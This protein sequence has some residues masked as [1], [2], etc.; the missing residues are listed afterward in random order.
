MG[1]E[2]CEI[3]I[4]CI[5]SEQNTV[6]HTFLCIFGNVMNMIKD[7][8]YVI[9][10]ILIFRVILCF[11]LVICVAASVYE[12]IF[13]PCFNSSNTEENLNP[14]RRKTSHFKSSSYSVTYVNTEFVHDINGS[15]PTSNSAMHNKEIN[16]HLD[17][18]QPK[19][20]SKWYLCFFKYSSI[21]LVIISVHVYG[22]TYNMCYS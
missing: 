18:Q 19:P 8:L 4:I 9:V 20:L 15:S 10:V 3:I 21:A 1:N 7:L 2:L 16:L 22:K 6:I 14:T 11:F 12:G 17:S 5:I 13:K